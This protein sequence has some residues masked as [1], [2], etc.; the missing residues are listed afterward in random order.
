MDEIYSKWNFFDVIYTLLTT[1]KSELF[2]INY[3]FMVDIVLVTLSILLLL[4]IVHLLVKGFLWKT[5]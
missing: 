3:Q 1:N 5:N 4:L 2:R